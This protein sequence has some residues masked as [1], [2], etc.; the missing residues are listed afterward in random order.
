[1]F[2]LRNNPAE[3]ENLAA[4]HS[5]KASELADIFRAWEDSF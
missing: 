1:L 2:D 5:S 3:L 4:R